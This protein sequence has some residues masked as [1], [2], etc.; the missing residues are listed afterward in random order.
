MII[1]NV[2]LGKPSFCVL[3]TEDPVRQLASKLHSYLCTN[4]HTDGCGWFYEMHA[5]TKTDDWNGRTHGRY[6]QKA[7]LLIHECETKKISAM[8]ALD[9]YAMVRNLL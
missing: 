7:R 9:T 2:S 5:D 4:N 3:G 1:D 6:L 8:D